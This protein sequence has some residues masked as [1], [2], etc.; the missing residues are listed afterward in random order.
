MREC[1]IVG[2]PIATEIPQ[3]ETVSIPTSHLTRRDVTRGLV[4]AGIGGAAIAAGIGPAAAQTITVTHYTDGLPGAPYVFAWEENLFEK[5]GFKLAAIQT[6]SGGGTTIRNM[7][8][9]DFPYGQ[10]SLSSA[11]EARR[12]G[13]DLT[14]VHSCTS[15]VGDFSV[16][17]MPDAPIKEPRDLIGK[18][19][20]YTNPASLTHMTMLAF[21][22]KVGISP[23]QVTMQAAGGIGAQLTALRSGKLDTA[24]ITEPFTARE[25]GKLREAFEIAKYIPE[26]IQADVGVVKSDFAKSHRNEVKSIIA[27]RRK[28]VETMYQDPARTAAVINKV[29]KQNP[30][31]IEEGTKRLIAIRFW[32]EG[33]LDM[34][35]MDR[36]VA[37]MKKVGID[38]GFLK[39][40][41]GIVDTSYLT[42]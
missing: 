6:S 17:T 27:A 37:A 13:I 34:A 8:A 3:E 31:V 32:D 36:S 24:I 38:V 18:R 29:Y 39:G 20:G 35:A 4:H 16:V 11:L 5:A 2:R 14:I 10:V 28:A 1:R 21:L 26:R 22:D 30:A 15:T 23:S 25:R 7:M 12:S 33:P 41:D 40:W 9:S 42:S 19:I